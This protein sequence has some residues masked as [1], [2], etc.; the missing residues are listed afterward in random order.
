MFYFSEWKPPGGKVISVTGC[1]SSQIVCAAGPA[2]YYVEVS[3]S[4][5]KNRLNYS[6]GGENV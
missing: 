3:C 1:N 4:G 6:V 5:R 2:L